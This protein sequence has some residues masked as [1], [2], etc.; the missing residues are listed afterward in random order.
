MAAAARGAAEFDHAVPRSAAITH[1]PFDAEMQSR[2]V[3]LSNKVSLQRCLG[4]CKTPSAGSLPEPCRG[5]VSPDTCG[6]QRTLAGNCS[7]S[8]CK[9]LSTLSA[10]EETYLPATNT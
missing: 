5:F 4:A 6:T 1:Q 10:S 3:G 9:V 7:R 2:V 8:L